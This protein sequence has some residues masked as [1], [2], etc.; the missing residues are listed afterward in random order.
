MPLYNSQHLYKN[1][2]LHLHF[3]LCLCCNYS[4]ITVITIFLFY[5]NFYFI[6]I[7][8]SSIVVYMSSIVVY[9]FI[10]VYLGLSTLT[11]VSFMLL[12]LYCTVE[13]A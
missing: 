3:T 12:F 11:C 7:I 13:G 2:C 6:L 9:L 5:S 8:M 1:V 10:F 4:C